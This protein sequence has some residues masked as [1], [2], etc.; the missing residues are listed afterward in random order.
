MRVYSFIIYVNVLNGSS[1][2]NSQVYETFL[3]GIL[4]FYAVLSLKVICA[5]NL[6]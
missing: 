1:F 6:K 4:L 3:S 2:I 5:I